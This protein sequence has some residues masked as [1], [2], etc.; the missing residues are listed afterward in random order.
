MN[1]NQNN[2]NMNTT[3]PSIINSLVLCHFNTTAPA[4]SVLNRCASIRVVAS[5]NAERNAAR[6][7]NTVINSKGTAVG[8]AISLLQRTGVA[9][10]RCGL[11]CPLGG[12]YLRVKD[13]STVQNIFDDAQHDLDIVRQDILSTYSDLLVSVRRKLGAF[14]R[15]ISLPTATEVSSRFTM[16]MTIIN[17]PVAGGEGVL[18][19]IATEV[20]NKVRAESQKQT[21]DLLRNAHVGPINDLKD[22]LALFID[23]MR[24]ATRL[25]M[26]QFDKLRDEALR[27]KGLNILDLPEINEVIDMTMAAASLPITELTQD[28]RVTVARKAERASE[29]ADET[30]AALGF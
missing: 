7:Y 25:H 13:I 24:N 19:G 1:P 8:R 6:V 5:A 15:D 2:T 10:R 20:A 27:V 12:I 3:T 4:T 29:K 28:E 9:I 17:Q 23:R 18:S 11:P 30:L 16:S 21:A 22:Q 26:S 14:T